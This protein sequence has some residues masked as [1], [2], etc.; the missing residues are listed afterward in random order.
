MNNYEITHTKTLS[1]RKY[2]LDKDKVIKEG[3]FI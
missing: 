1:C 3:I 2:T